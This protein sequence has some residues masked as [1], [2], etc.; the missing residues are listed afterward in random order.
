MAGVRFGDSG[1]NWIK[2]PATFWGTVKTSEFSRIRRS[3]KDKEKR[4]LFTVTLAQVADPYLGEVKSAIKGKSGSELAELEKV[5]RTGQAYLEVELLE[6]DWRSYLQG[7]GIADLD[8]DG[9]EPR[10][11]PRKPGWKDLCWLMPVLMLTK[12]KNDNPNEM[13]AESIAKEIYVAAVKAE[14]AGLPKEPTI[15][16]TV[17][18][19]IAELRKSAPDSY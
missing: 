7:R 14:I 18:K 1:V 19:M 12:H 5:V 16:D 9:Q 3:Y 17:S 10:G 2:I 13:N 15:K 4:G 6:L 11:A 8:I